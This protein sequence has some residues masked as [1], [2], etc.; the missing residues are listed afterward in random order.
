MN[1][2]TR[3]L[4]ILEEED[5]HLNKRLSGIEEENEAL[6]AGNA[7]L[8]KRLSSIEDENVA[9]KAEN[10]DLNKR[11]TSIEEE[12]ILLKTEDARLDKRLSSIDDDNHELMKNVMFIK[13][14]S[15]TLKEK[16]K[17]VVPVNNGLKHI[18]STLTYNHKYRGQKRLLVPAGK[19]IRLVF[20]DFMN[21]VGHQ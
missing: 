18:T 20:N 2:I 16:T 4:Y 6:K 19:F 5:A 10:A 8:N 9:L 3:W 11:L 1:H 15:N 14:L 12:N 7:H 17:T 21:N 13:E